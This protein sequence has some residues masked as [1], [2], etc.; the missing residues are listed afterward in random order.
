MKYKELFIL[1]LVCYISRIPQLISPD[2]MLD[3]DECV[4]AVMARHMLE[5]REF[6]VYFYGQPY[7]FSFIEV[8]FIDLHYFFFGISDV[9]VK[10]GMLMMW[11]LGI[12]LFY[13]TLLMIRLKNDWIP[14]CIALIFASAPVWAV[15]SMKARGGYLTAFLFTNLILFLL[16]RN[17]DTQRRWLWILIGILTA[18]VF[19]GQA[20]WLPGLL[21]IIVYQLYRSGNKADIIKFVG[22]IAIGAITFFLIKRNLM[23]VWQPEVFDLKSGILHRII[24]LPRRIYVNFSGSYYVAWNVEG[25]P[26]TYLWAGCMTALLF[27]ALLVLMPLLVS[28]AAS[29]YFYVFGLSFIFSLSYIFVL[30]DNA[31]RY[32]LP[33]FGNLLLFIAILTDQVNFKKLI[34]ALTC[35]F[36]LAGTFSICTFYKFRFKAHNK[37]NILH[38]I[39]ELKERNIYHVF[40]G[41]GLLQWQIIFYSN[42]EITT[43]FSTWG[44]RYPKNLRAV[45]EAFYSKK[46]R[47]GV[48]GTINERSPYWKKFVNVDDQFYINEDPSEILLHNYGFTVERPLPD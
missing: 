32:L 47:I 10:L 43:R 5:G 1:I 2:L 15:W 4:V 22:G 44:E 34:I 42:E 8:L 19:E 38:L 31:A 7:G 24:D 29:P 23:N 9:T 11:T 3:G 25:H 20:L 45:N 21:P 48:V 13:K 39:D 6:P 14:F 16:F 17:Q 12:L 18:I 30:G 33:L 37:E 27:L 28:R 46:H 40:C 35:F 26:V 41:N 36:V